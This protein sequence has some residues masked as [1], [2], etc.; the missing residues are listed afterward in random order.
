MPNVEQPT[1]KRHD[2]SDFCEVCH[3]VLPENHLVN[4]AINLHFE[5][6]TCLCMGCSHT[7]VC[8]WLASSTVAY[9]AK[10]QP[11]IAQSSTE[12]EFMDTLDFCK[13]L[14]YVCSILWDLG[15]PQQVAS[16][17]Y[18]DNDACMAIAMA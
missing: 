17:F 18:E 14:L 11:T 4:N 9:K 15:V 10:L 1:T 3:N 13:I 8:M 6:A 7:S 2:A 16:V 5:W 12:A